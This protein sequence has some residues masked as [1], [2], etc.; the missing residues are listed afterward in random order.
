[1]LILQAG[2]GLFDKVLF[3]CELVQSQQLPDS[4]R[5]SFWHQGL[6]LLLHLRVVCLAWSRTQQSK[7]G[8]H[9]LPHRLR[10]P[11]NKVSLSFPINKQT[12]RHRGSLHSAAV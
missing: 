5:Y 11:A 7:V 9:H 4:S 10:P 12:A 6:R 2:R 8:H 3:V 1:M